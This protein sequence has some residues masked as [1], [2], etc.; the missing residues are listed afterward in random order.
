MTLPE[1]ITDALRDYTSATLALRA[2]TENRTIVDKP[3]F[4]R[5]LKD[6]EECRKR[7]FETSE[8]SRSPAIIYCIMAMNIQYDNFMDIYELAYN[9]D[10]TPLDTDEHDTH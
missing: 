5:R 10:G 4:E 1:D 3:A 7:F 9:D 2:T 8:A 6:L